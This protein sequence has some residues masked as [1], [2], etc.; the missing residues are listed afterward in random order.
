MKPLKTPKT[1]SG[2]APGGG[3]AVRFGW[4]VAALAFLFTGLFVV[5]FFRLWFVQLVEGEELAEQADANILTLEYLEAPRG[6]IIDRNG[7]PLAVSTSRI[8]LEVDRAELPVEEEDDVIQRL[9]SL[10]G[11]TPVEV[12]ALLEEAGSGQV[13]VISE[14][15]IGAD[16]A[17]QILEQRR[18]LPGVAVRVRPVRQYLQGELMGHVLGHIGLPDQEDLDRLPNI[19]VETVVGKQGVELQYDEFLQGSLGRVS[20]R[21]APNGDILEEVG[22]IDPVPGDTVHLTLDIPTQQVAERV[23]AEAI[24]L[25]NDLKEEA[26]P[27]EPPRISP[28]AERAAALVLDVNTGEVRAMASHPTFAP[29]AFVGGIDVAAFEELS[30]K[31]AFNNLVIQGLK[32][33][34]ST[35]KAVTYVTAMEEDIFPEDAASPEDAID[36]SAQLEADFV[37]QSQLV[38]R[39]W[40]YPEDD[41]RQNLH[42]AFQRSCNIYFW[43]IALSIWRAYSRTDR[44]DLVQQWADQIGFGRR[45]QVDLPFENPGVLPDR[46]LFE[47]WRRTQPWRVRP[48]GWL[49]GDLMSLVVGQGSILATPLQLAVAYSSLVNGGV[50][51]QPWVVDRVVSSEGELVIDNGPRVLRTVDISPFTVES[52]RRDLAAVVQRGTAAKAFEEMGPLSARISG[53]TGT[54]QSFTDQEGVYHDSTAWF[55]GVLPADDPQWVV[56]VMVDEGGSGGAVAAPAARAIMQHLLQVPVT[57]LVAGEETER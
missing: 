31:Q 38:W 33:P 17:Y 36:C 32:P 51:Y 28:P 4:R 19:D 37:D 45:S 16:V 42:G 46:E 15:D 52:L 53:K 8:V 2:D 12:R 3:L 6:N 44:E 21:Q 49:G 39:N 35:F 50:V 18:T 43:E 34:A 20:Y 11:V 54:A 40:T 14:M 27:E 7:I 41:G 25:A 13:A 57:P 23:L 26:E 47:R 29:Q 30:E 55:A 1:P 5:L 24:E 9:A 10:L 56:V 48:E 22:Q